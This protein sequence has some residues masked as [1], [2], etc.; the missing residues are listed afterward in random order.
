MLCF[1]LRCLTHERVCAHKRTSRNRVSA[2][3]PRAL[4]P[5]TPRVSAAAAAAVLLAGFYVVSRFLG[6]Q[7]RQTLDPLL[8]AAKTLCGRPWPWVQEH[9]GSHV[10]VE[11]YCTWAPYVVH[12][13]LHGLGLEEHHVVIAQDGDLGW[14][15]GA[16][17]VEASRLPGFSTA[18]APAAGS[19]Q[20]RQHRKHGP[21][22]KH[23][24]LRGAASVLQQ[25][26][27]KAEAAPTVADATPATAPAAGH[28]APALQQHTASSQ[29]AG[30]SWSLGLLHHNNHPHTGLHL[31]GPGWVVV[32]VVAWSIIVAWCRGV[33]GPKAAGPVAFLPLTGIVSTA[34]AGRAQVSGHIGRGK[35]SPI[36]SFKN[37]SL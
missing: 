11:R 24:S 27:V 25:A 15:L 35:V 8:D 16:V 21:R 26:E 18:S 12:L 28:L 19:R 3:S 33:C 2:P 23:S 9:L 6:V 10:N 37:A 30:P 32:L 29:Q 4:Q 17:L 7:G 13:L 5:R 34:G 20:Q 14:P 36:R 31:S 1:R 22:S